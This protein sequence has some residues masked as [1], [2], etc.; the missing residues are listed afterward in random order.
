M[1]WHSSTFSPLFPVFFFLFPLKQCMILISISPLRLCD[2][3]TSA[4]DSTTESEILSALKTLANN[5][6]SIF[7]AHRLTTAMQCDE[8]TVVGSD[9]ARLCKIFNS[10]FYMHH[11]AFD[12]C[13]YLFICFSISTMFY[14]LSTPS[15]NVSPFISHYFS[16]LL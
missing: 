14:L 6:T 10:L 7:I 4:L 13:I 9:H 11:V 8:V 15:P 16:L 5:R 2:E 3:A 12:A 1:G